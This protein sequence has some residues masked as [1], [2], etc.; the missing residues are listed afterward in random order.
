MWGPFCRCSFWMLSN[1]GSIGRPHKPE[2]RICCCGSKI[3]KRSREA[4]CS[5]SEVR[6]LGGSNRQRGHLLSGPRGRMLDHHSVGKKK[7]WGTQSSCGY[8]GSPAAK[9]RRLVLW[10]QTEVKPW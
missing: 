7:G 5:S 6:F 4:E 8:L 10:L 1:G 9:G 3:Q 2:R